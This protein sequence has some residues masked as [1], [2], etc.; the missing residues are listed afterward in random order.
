MG[1]TRFDRATASLVLFSTIVETGRVRV[2]KKFV[3]MKRVDSSK[4]MDIP[5]Q[6]QTRCAV[7][8][9][10]WLFPLNL[11]S[12]NCITTNNSESVMK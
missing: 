12:H 11:K 1:V 3:K 10:H 6:Q 4:C 5:L 9:N 7:H 8:I 2:A